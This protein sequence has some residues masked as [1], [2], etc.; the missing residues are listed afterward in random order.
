[1]KEAVVKV[2]YPFRY[3]KN[4][5]YL[6]CQNSDPSSKYYFGKECK[7]WTRI[8]N[9]AAVA[10]LCK[11]CTG[12]LVPPPEEKKRADQNA[13]KFPRGWKFKSLFVASNLDV[14]FKGILQPDLHGKYEATP[15]V[16]AKVKEKK[17]KLSKNARKELKYSLLQE[18][19]KIRTSLDEPTKLNLAESMKISSRKLEIEK[20]LKTL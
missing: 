10:V 2:Q 11:S 9:D 14:Y 4:H 3:Y 18:L 6:L 16:E 7:N 13:I 17:P 20:Q 19:D 1:M 15:I 12:R 5:K 8:T